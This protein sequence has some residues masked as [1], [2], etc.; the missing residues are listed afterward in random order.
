MPPVLECANRFGKLGS[1]LASSVGTVDAVLE[2][3]GVAVSDVVSVAPVVGDCG[4]LAPPPPQAAAVNNPQSR[5]FLFML[6]A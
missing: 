6:A 5:V 2:P 1:G 4:G 3:A